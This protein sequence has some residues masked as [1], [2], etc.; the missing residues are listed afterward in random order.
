MDLSPAQ[1]VLAF[2]GIVVVLGGMG[3]YLLIPGVRSALGQ[4][5]GAAAATPS[6][7]AAG[8]AG[9]SPSVPPAST[10]PASQASPAPAGSVPDIYQWLPFSQADLAKA[11]RVAEAF[12]AAY[13]TFSY[14][15]GTSSYVASLRGLATTELSATLARA[16]GTPGVASQRTRQQQVS[17]AR[18][19]INSI[20]TF[21]SGSL[22]FVVTIVQTMHT[23]QGKSQNDGHYA[24]TLI[25]SG[26]SWLVNDV[27]LASA[28]NT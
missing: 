21:S 25:G 16:Y 7:S 11:A 13:D 8:A 23:K 1:R 18:T 14:R 6:A 2:L 28:G 17:S 4:G 24:I 20:R 9:P 15:N 3:A 5:H 12:G 10:A 26:Q 19:V 27:E 22:T